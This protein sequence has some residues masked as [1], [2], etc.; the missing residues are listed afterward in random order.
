[1]KFPEDCMP[2]PQ[3]DE[4]RAAWNRRALS[5]LPEA[6]AVPVGQ[7]FEQW[8]DQFQAPDSW[9][10]FARKAW[11]AALQSS[12]P[13]QT[14]AVDGEMVA[15]VR[16]RVADIQRNFTERSDNRIAAEALLARLEAS[17][18]S[19]AAGEG[20]AVDG[21]C[22]ECA[23]TGFKDKGG[24]RL[25]LARTVCGKCGGAGHIASLASQASTAKE[26]DKCP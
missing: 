18:A 23:G 1:V 14:A 19:Q 7:T 5:A 21:E 16:E 3:I 4:C 12:P 2:G 8:A 13:V 6:P 9:I 15:F 25:T 17:L 22:S 24:A 26:A 20:E 11:D 10:E